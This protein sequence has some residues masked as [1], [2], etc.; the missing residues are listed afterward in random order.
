MHSATHPETEERHRSISDPDPLTSPLSPLTSDPVSAMNAARQAIPGDIVNKA[1]AD[2]PDNQRSAIRRFHAYYTEKDLSLAEASELLE[3]SPTSG[4]L[5]LVFHGRY[6]AKL[7]GIIARINRF[8]GD[9][10]APSRKLDFIETKLTQ[11]IWQVCDVAL[12]FQKIGFIYGDQQIGKSEA[13]KAYQRAHNH[14]STSYVEV[15][16]G[17]AL[18]DFLTVLAER[19][20]I[21]PFQRIA[22]LRRRII[23]AFD[24]RMLLIVDEAHRTVD[25]MA[26][27][28][29]VRTIEFIRELFNEKQC[30]VVICATNVLRDAM[31]SGPLEK[32]LRQARR[33]RLA[34][35]QLP[36]TPTQEDLNIFAA[37]YGLPPSSGEA[38]KLE[39]RMIEHE[40]LGMW[41]TLLR[42][43]A[44]VAAQQN[45][46]QTT[47]KMDWSHVL[48]AHKGLQ[49]LESG[50]R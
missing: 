18:L 2:L 36:S 42:M 12:E 3:L 6:G 31:D 39:T 35:V 34:A 9:L 32:I 44:K 16:T 43:A 29:S 7:D 15:P 20:R 21:S 40:A 10:S 30:G 38:R 33:R 22:V 47:V 1:T 27:A 28:R 26:G 13:L 50:L 17:G 4:S 48:T 25:D 46:G 19:L 45:R 5:S 49:A 41:L 14:G 11:R 24:K 37:A 8:F 23:N